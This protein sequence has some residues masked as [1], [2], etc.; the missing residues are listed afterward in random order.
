MVFCVDIVSYNFNTVK[1]IHEILYKYKT[2][3]SN[4]QRAKS[5]T[6]STLFTE[7]CP[8]IIFRM[9]TGPLYNFK[10]ITDIFTKLALNIKQCQLMFKE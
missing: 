3:T 9:E 4:M 8:F 2:S 5:F 10:I 7:F 6:P 1:N